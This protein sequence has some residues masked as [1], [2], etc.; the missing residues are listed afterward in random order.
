VSVGLIVH[1]DN[2]TLADVRAL[3]REA[4]DAGADWLGVPDAFW[5]RDTWVLVAELARV[6][7]R[8]SIGPLVT[9]PYTRHPFVTVAAIATLQEL[10]GPRVLVGL[11]AGGSEV[12]G[13][14]QISRADAPERTENL[15]A[16]I[17]TVAAG[18]P[19]DRP[20]GRT[21]EV[22]L[23]RP[24]IIVGGRGPRML[25]T[26]GRSA[27]DALLWAVPRSE[28]EHTVGLVSKGAVDRSAGLAAVK[29]IWAPLVEHDAAS[30]SLLRRAATYA[31]LN[32]RPQVRQRWGV[33]NDRVRRVRQLL[34][35][36]DLT[37][38]AAEV[39][40]AVADDLATGSDAAAAAA[41]ARRIGASGIALPITDV[42]TVGDRVVWARQVLAGC[43]S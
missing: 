39:P 14:A 3:G 15:A 29:F 22:P 20:S 16:L 24:R 6:T 36:G 19:L 28:L 26:A 7:E 41:L 10:A 12:G 38:A 9:N 5:W 1:L 13:A 4:E 23:T 32:N 21:L 31:L 25:A 37:N 40:V 35:A 8:L 30:R 18:E 43:R 33:D 27:D 2:P 11:G 34:L 17:R 42:A